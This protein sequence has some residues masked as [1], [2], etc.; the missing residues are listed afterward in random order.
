VLSALNTQQTW[1]KVVLY[2]PSV[3]CKD[4]K[5]KIW[6]IGTSAGSRGPG[7]AVGYAESNDGFRWKE[8]EGNPILTDD[9]IPWGEGWQTPFVLFD[10]EENVYRM[11]FSATTKMVPNSRIADAWM[12]TDRVL[13][14]A[15]S[16]D[17]IQWEVHPR[18]VYRDGSRSPCVLKDGPNRYRM[19]MNVDYRLIYEFTS[20]NGIDWKRADEPAIRPSGDSRT[21]IYPFVLREN[22]KYYMWYGCHRPNGLFEIFCA[23][24]PDGSDS[25][26]TVTAYE[27]APIRSASTSRISIESLQL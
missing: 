25:E 12:P 14:Y 19:W 26:S 24:S 6:Y 1:C 7:K 5:F 3:L 2:S 23:T 27:P 17:G 9:D 15:T 21:C 22:G 13:G 10:E 16:S 8:Y 11:W 20:S 4:G 18:P